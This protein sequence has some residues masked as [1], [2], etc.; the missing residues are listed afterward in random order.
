MNKG[1]AKAKGVTPFNKKV[2]KG[3]IVLTIRP[4]KEGTVL[5]TFAVG[6]TVKQAVNHTG[7]GSVDDNGVYTL[8]VYSDEQAL[9]LLKTKKLVDGTKVKIER[10]AHRNKVKC[11]IEHKTIT[12][13]PDEALAGKLQDQG[14]IEVRS[15]KP[16]RRLKIIT[17]K[18]TKV[19]AHIQLGLL[20]VKTRTYYN[21]PKTCRNCMELGHITE[22]CKNGPRCGVCSGSHKAG[23]CN[24]TPMCINCGGDHPPLN[25]QC[26]AYSQEKAIIKILTDGKVHPR[27]ARNMYKAKAKGRYI[28]LPAELAEGMS[29]DSEGDNDNIEADDSETEMASAADGD[30]ETETADA[31]ADK[32]ALPGALMKATKRKMEQKAPPPPKRGRT[33][34]PT[35][36]SEDETDSEGTEEANTSNTS[37]RMRASPEDSEKSNKK[38][39]LKARK[40]RSTRLSKTENAEVA[41]PPQQEEEEDDFILEAE[42]EL[43][44]RRLA[45]DD[46]E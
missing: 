45:E 1:Q 11:L 43:I 8:K 33:K 6:D 21:M 34:P 36:A 18:G 13:Y 2:K 44:R 37:G 29:T 14:V 30:S 5:D 46:D 12:D 23:G 19:P 16:E 15:I 24:G 40:R 35:P 3:E 22:D 28:P 17:L 42:K 39:I 31:A 7:K 27:R 32:P 10:D 26:P 9:K 41:T 20:R 38:D 4:V 25:K